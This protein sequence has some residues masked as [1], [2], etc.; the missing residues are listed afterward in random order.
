MMTKLLRGLMIALIIAITASA[1]SAETLM[2][3]KRDARMGST[4]VIWGVTT[5]ASVSGCTIDY[6]DATPAGNC[7]A[8]DRSFIAFNHTYTTQGTFTATL[9]VGA[10]SATT[11]VQVFDPALLPGGAA[12]D[13]NRSL[14]INMSIQ[15]G[16]RYLWVAQASRAANF[17]SV[18][19]TN[20][21]G[22]YPY[23]DA[24]LI[25]LAFENHGYKMPTN[26]ATAPT[27]LYE[28]Y[29]VRR[30]LNYTMSQLSAVTL[31]AQAA[32]SPCVAGLGVVAGDCGGLTGP[33]SAG[34]STAVLTLPFAASGSLTRVN[35]EVAGATAGMTYGQILQ[36]LVNTEAWG[37]S[38][39]TC[40]GRGGFGYSHNGCQF[41]G[42]TVGWSILGFLDAEAAGATIPSF[43]RTEFQVGFNGALNN[44]GTFDYREDNNPATATEPNP[45]KAGIGLQ[46]L[47]FT[48]VSAPFAAGSKGTNTVAYISSR[49]PG[50]YG[51]GDYG[52]WNCNPSASFNKGCGYTMFNNFKG[53]KLQGI[54]TL[55]GVT[56]PAGPGAQPAG[57]WYAD[58]QDYLVANQVA[59]TN[60]NN[61]NWNIG[62]SCCYSSVPIGTAIAE[63]ILSPV[64]LVL[65]DELKFSTVGLS[66]V[67][68]TATYGGSHTVTAKAESTGGTPVPGATVNFLI[69]TGP[70]AGLTGTGTTGAAGTATFTYNGV[71]GVGTDTIKATIGTLSSN[72]VEMNWTP[73]SVVVNFTAANK[74]YDGGVAA[75]I[76]GCSIAGVLPADAAGVTCNFAGATATFVDPI[77]GNGKVVTGSGFAMAGAKAGNYLIAAINSTTANITKRDASVTANGGTKVYGSAD[78]ALTASA[79]G[80]LPADGI[81]LSETRVAG[82]PIGNY[83]TTATAAGAALGNYNVTYVG[84][85]F[86]ITAKAAT[87][88][89]N[90][91]TKVYGSADPALTASAIG[92]LLADGITLSETR[93]AGDSVGNYATT[94]TAVG[95]ALGNYNVT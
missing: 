44:D 52:G 77:V 47:Y 57:D 62:F 34:Y 24:A 23:A 43:V 32:G 90:G 81:T 19:T 13:N 38:D 68:N 60:G 41:D 73:V 58:Y 14:G 31:T 5:Q 61:G 48:G 36:R 4:L 89:A 15:D 92:F 84:G 26:P 39:P 7:N 11:Q 30:G 70:N 85:N 22:G 53:L 79:I 18:V 75:T 55:A 65:P 49:W 87:V 21:G 9:T 50:A 59:P 1:A 28:K 86:S 80:F 33:G 67:T 29:L 91:G 93:V 66:P 42:S 27:G 72:I 78:P 16:L 3:P 74:V 10:E 94:A 64:A 76:T 8:F 88:T 40:G 82:E 6:G 95:A 51:A 12:G 35:T 69:L 83:A 20:W 17:P 45:Q 25:V 71:G 46:G 37:Q 2:M 56:R 63:L 54:T